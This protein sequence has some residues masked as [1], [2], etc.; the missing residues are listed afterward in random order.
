MFSF[1]L[2]IANPSSRSYLPPLRPYYTGRSLEC[3]D[4]IVKLS[5]ESTRLLNIFGSPGFGKTSTAIA[6][7]HVLQAQGH[8]VYFSNFQGVI[9]KHDF[10]SKIL[11]LFWRA[12]TSNANVNLAPTDELCCIFYEISCRVFIIL[13]DL[14]DVLACSSV[15]AGITSVKDEVLHFIEEIL[16]RCQNVRFLTTARQ[17]LEF[18]D[19]WV[20][21]HQ[22]RAFMPRCL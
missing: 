4:I 10:I 7:G 3:E 15:G 16:C 17:S 14:D 21:E 19:C 13:D 5:S 6:A 18:E 1:N 20:S 2:G 9:S 22:D 11:S 12:T 8:S